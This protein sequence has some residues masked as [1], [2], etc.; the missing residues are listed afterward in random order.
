MAADPASTECAKSGNRCSWPAPEQAPSCPRRAHLR[1]AHARGPAGRPEADP[2]RAN[3]RK[4]PTVCC[5]AIDQMAARAQTTWVR[6]WIVAYITVVERSILA[7]RVVKGIVRRQEPGARRDLASGGW[8]HDLEGI[9]KRLGM[10]IDKGHI[11]PAPMSK[12]LRAC[13]S[14]C[15]GR[16]AGIGQRRPH[17]LVGP[18]RILTIAKESTPRCIV[19][20]RHLD[21]RRNRFLCPMANIAGVVVIAGERIGHRV[22]L[23]VVRR[24][25][26]NP[27][28]GVAGPEQTWRDGH[29]ASGGV[30]RRGGN[31]N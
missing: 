22:G 6:E 19:N 26:L 9:R 15:K 5:L 29:V 14:K 4:T 30:A 25:L 21:R 7:G 28:I 1:L 17:E 10:P 24:A 12:S 23:A 18:G 16:I 31:P 8:R 11:G 20:L 27:G 13:R 2:R 3:G